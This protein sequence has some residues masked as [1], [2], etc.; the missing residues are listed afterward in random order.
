[1][2]FIASQACSSAI[3][4]NSNSGNVISFPVHSMGVLQYHEE[5]LAELREQDGV[6]VM[7]AGLGLHKLIA[8]VVRLHSITSNPSESPEALFVVGMTDEQRQ[9]RSN[10]VS[11]LS[12]RIL[13]AWS[14]LIL[15]GLNL[16]DYMQYR[17][18][19]KSWRNWTRGREIRRIP[20]LG[21]IKN[22]HAGSRILQRLFHALP[23]VMVQMHHR[24]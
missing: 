14:D 18:C 22:I 24:P 12:A 7:A 21:L 13:F 23:V 4:S 2:F 1:M 20:T 3:I 16:L 8:L 15:F 19:K 5:M 11:T 17:L 6:L 9:V 10:S